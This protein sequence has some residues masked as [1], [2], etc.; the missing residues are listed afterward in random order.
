MLAPVA[1]PAGLDR[2]SCDV[3]RDHDRHPPFGDPDPRHGLALDDFAS[4]PDLPRPLAYDHAAVAALHEDHS[5]AFQERL[6][7]LT[8]RPL[9]LQT[10]PDADPGAVTLVDALDEGGCAVALEVDLRLVPI[11][12][13]CGEPVGGMVCGG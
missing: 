10:P 7:P 13:G 1:P 8:L 12:Y 3:A 11:D 4:N 2:G 9:Q 6:Q 5:L